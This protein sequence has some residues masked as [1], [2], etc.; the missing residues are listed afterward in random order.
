MIRN[1]QNITA[2]LGI[3]S[4]TAARI[5]AGVASTTR[6]CISQQ[7]AIAKVRPSRVEVGHRLGR[8]RRCP[9]SLECRPRLHAGV[10]ARLVFVF[11]NP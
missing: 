10:D 11:S 6:A 5:C 7:Q 4:A 3:V 8:V 2:T 9:E 1:D